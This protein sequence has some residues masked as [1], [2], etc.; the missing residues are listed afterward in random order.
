[1]GGLHVAL[2]RWLALTVRPAP[3]YVAPASGGRWA[4]HA[5]AGGSAAP[6]VPAA[7]WRWPRDRAASSSLE[8]SDDPEQPTWLCLASN[9]HCKMPTGSSRSDIQGARSS[10]VGGTSSSLGRG[11]DPPPARLLAISG[12]WLTGEIHHP[13][14]IVWLRTRRIHRSIAGGQASPRV[15]VWAS[16]ASTH[17]GSLAG[18]TIQTRHDGADQLRGRWPAAPGW[19]MSSRS[20]C[21]S[22]TR[23]L[24]QL[25][26]ESLVVPFCSRRPATLPSLAS[27][28]RT[29]RLDPG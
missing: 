14:Q 28:A 23:R 29:P 3:G 27:T 2:L 16:S 11:F 10:A 1:M 20:E 22:R 6:A 21:C 18:D 24:H 9:V 15:F 4:G 25:N 17:T 5:D 13:R 7:R 19:T 26:R 12:G 8:S